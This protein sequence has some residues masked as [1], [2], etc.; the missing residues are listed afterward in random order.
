[1]RRPTLRVFIHEVIDD[2]RQRGILLA[3][4]LALLTVG[5]GV[6]SWWDWRP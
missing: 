2:P 3:G 6:S 4:V 1:M 5:L